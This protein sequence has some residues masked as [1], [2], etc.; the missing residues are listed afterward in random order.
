MKKDVAT[1]NRLS[2]TVPQTPGE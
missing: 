2:S 1:T